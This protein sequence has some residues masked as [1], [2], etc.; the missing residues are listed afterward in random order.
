VK[1][2]KNVWVILAGLVLILG[3]FGLTACG[4]KGSG[5]SIKIS[6][7]GD[8][9]ENQILVDLIAQFEKENPT[10]KVELQR[11]PF[12]EYTTKL[13]T[14]IAAGSAPDVI[15]TET[16]NFVDLYLRQAFEPLNAYIQKDNFSTADY[17]P[18][19]LDRFSADGN[20]YAIP[21]DTAPICVIYYNKKAFDEAKL[22]YPNDDW[23][24]AQFVAVGQKLIKKDATG[25]VT[26]WA[27]I[28][29]WSMFEP[30]IY[31][32]GGKWADDVKKPTK[33]LMA[34]D[35]GF[36]TGIQFRAD[37]MHKYKVMPPPA[38]L[39][40]MGGMGT[41]DM[42]MNGTVAMFLSGIW[43]TPK[44][45]TDIKNFKWDVVMFPKGPTGIRAF[46]TGGSGYGILKSSQNKEAAW[47]LVK[48][49]S[50]PVGAKKLAQTGLAQPAM[51]SVASGPDFLDGKDP[52]NKK[53]VLEAVKYVKY[54]PMAK[55][56]SEVQYGILG[57]IL[58]KV[59]NGNI[60]AQQAA[61]ALKPQLANKPPVTQ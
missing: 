10:I 54:M 5:T 45:R 43:K 59:W 29:D 48:F 50:G 12:N 38:S 4:K 27:F 15:F 28:D 13:L 51:M 57:P 55:N 25:K 11:I 9:S 42:F 24:W 44:F 35:Q 21:R 31:S 30:W 26:R 32:A 40:A 34:E 56:T 49:I 37:L 19:I 7:W 1:V 22:P 8:L 23:N 16:N 52:Q 3:A 61:E 14:Q 18:Q 47:K 41:S 33:W 39:S 20:I 53:M 36:V 46:G 58:D 6:S 60:T 17:Y 2:L